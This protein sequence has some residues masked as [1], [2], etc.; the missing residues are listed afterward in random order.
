[1]GLGICR[2][3]RYPCGLRV[4]V[5]DGARAVGGHHVWL[6]SVTTA[7]QGTQVC[8]GMGPGN[9]HNTTTIGYAHQSINYVILKKGYMRI[10]VWVSIS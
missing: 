8:R 1:M 2:G 3:F 7:S 4:G 5:H 10:G 9:K 6:I